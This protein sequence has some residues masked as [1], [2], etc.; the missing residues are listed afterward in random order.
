[1]RDGLSG[2]NRPNKKVEDEVADLA[3]LAVKVS[4]RE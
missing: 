2:A 4:Q 3:A 1:L